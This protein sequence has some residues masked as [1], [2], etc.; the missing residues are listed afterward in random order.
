[1]IEVVNVTKKYGSYTAIQDLN[2]TVADSSIYGLIGYNGAGKTT[3]LKTIAGV[4]KT[5]GGEVL[6]D[7][8]N[9]YENAARKQQMFYVPDDI[10]FQPY[11]S[12]EK[13]ARF[14]NGY[15]PNFSFDTFR[16]L[17][18]VF[19]LNTK[20]RLNGFSKGMQ[21]Q[22]ELVLGLSTNP[23]YLLLDESFDG[24]DPAKR[25]LIKNLLTD[26]LRD[27]DVSIIVSSHNLH[28]LEGLCDHFGIINGQKMA[29]NSSI[30]EMSK[31]RAKFRAV[32]Q[33]DV[34]REELEARG[35]AVKS[36]TPDG[37]IIQFTAV[38]DPREVEN[39]LQGLSPVLVEH[40]PLSLEEVFLDEM[41]GT[42]YDFSQIFQ[43]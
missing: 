39:A 11:A 1:M 26:Y 16:K 24:L 35:V 31:G 10:Y 38:G 34:T 13:M 37:K 15:Y 36:F 21:R 25:A 40:V 7:G 19:E 3:L 42:E 18:E 4:F 5:N 30:S 9:V 27:T 23:K 2:F 43:K 8:E 28:E 17:A 22:A 29:L 33:T 32:F 12:M 41:E 20:A 14:Y 6:L